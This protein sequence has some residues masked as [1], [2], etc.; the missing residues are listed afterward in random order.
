MF[1]ELE[2][3]LKSTVTKELLDVLRGALSCFDRIQ[4][5]NYQDGYVELLMLNDNVDITET[6][7]KIVIL[8]MELQKQLLTLH[9]VELTDDAT[10]YI[11]TLFIN[12]IMDI[13]ELN[14][15]DELLNI[16]SLNLDTNETFAELV[17]LVSD[18]SVEEL[19]P[20]I[21]SVSPAFI[22]AVRE[23]VE[24]IPD[25]LPEAELLVHQEYLTN[26]NKFCAFINTKDLNIIK[27]LE[28]GLSVGLPF[29]VYIDT[30]TES[31]ESMEL[32]KVSNELVAMALIS[33]DGYNNP[34]AIIKANLDAY[35]SDI[36]KITA[37]TIKT[38][39]I[40]TQF[41]K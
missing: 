36:N 28:N 33:S 41:I 26:I 29:L 8:T 21:K 14:E 15:K 35:I 9:N 4:F 24:N 39:D 12:S 19:L 7:D 30:I 23:Y 38:T 10:I 16:L 3:Y 31:I 32:D 25:K 2:Q 18:K 37:I 17:T 40:L 34:A 6:T 27:L 20:Y 11:N 13:Q 22:G 5:P 1:Y